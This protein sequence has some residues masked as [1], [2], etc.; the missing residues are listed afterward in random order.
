M[1]STP[2]SATYL[3]NLRFLTLNELLVFSVARFPHLQMRMKIIVATMISEE[4]LN[5]RKALR[6]VLPLSK[7]DVLVVP[8]SSGTPSKNDQKSQMNSAP[9]NF[10]RLCIFWAPRGHPDR[11]SR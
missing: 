8:H 9:M 1:G 11:G 7:S 2:E 10:S 4:L 5:I 3:A 6:A